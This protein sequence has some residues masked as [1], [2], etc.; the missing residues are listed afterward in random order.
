CQEAKT[1]GILKRGPLQPI[2]TSRPFQL[3]TCDILGPLPVT[4]EGAK[5]IIVFICHFTKWIELY[6]LKTLEAN[7][8]AK[9]FMDLVCRHGV[10]E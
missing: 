3:V 2:I 7:E 6:S 8:A 9:C 4:K 5:Y 10:P 1:N